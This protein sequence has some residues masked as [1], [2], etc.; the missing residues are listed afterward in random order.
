VRFALPFTTGTRPGLADYLPAPH[1]FAGFAAPVE[2]AV[3]ALVPYIE[4]PD[5]RTLVAA[6]GADRVEPAADGRS[7]KATW[8][9]WAQLG[10]RA[11][12]YVEPGLTTQVEWRLQGSTLAREERLISSA[13]LAIRTWRMTVPSTASH[14]QTL[15][16][17]PRID[18]FTGSEGRLG[19]TVVQSDWPIVVRGFATGDSPMGRGARGPI[20]FHLQLEARDV[21][22]DAGR[23]QGWTLRLSL[24]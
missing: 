16:G 15:T 21:R 14:W 1:G 18:V 8:S 10:G 23:P 4:L 22:L 9:R 12:E 3:P 20:P 7:V 24:E 13:P 5:G 11:A 17:P 6:D 2:Q 19:V